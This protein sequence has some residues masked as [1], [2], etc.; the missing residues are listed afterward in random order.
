MSWLSKFRQVQAKP[1]L[2]HDATDLESMLPAAV[3]GRTL[4]RWSAAGPNFWQ[5]LGGDRVQADWQTDLAN[6]GA[7][8]NEIEMAVAGRER[9]SD[10]P[11]IIWA[12][13]FGKLTGAQLRA[14]GPSA[15]AMAAMHVDANQGENWGDR[16]FGGKR[17]LIG[18][19]AMV[20]QDRH[21]RGIP[22]VYMAPSAIY[23]LIAD[24]EAWAEEAIRAL[25]DK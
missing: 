9:T 24:D 15:L 3:G 10:P 14:P 22:M 12:L 2:P 16:T 5:A 23:A 21:H 19:R 20:N 8:A 6:A 11:Y 4:V 17:V 7:S 25:P 18:H 13:R 1:I